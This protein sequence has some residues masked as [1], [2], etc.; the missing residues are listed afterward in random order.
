[1][2]TQLIKVTLVFAL[3]MLAACGGSTTG[4]AAAPRNVPDLGVPANPAPINAATAT[5]STGFSSA[6]GLFQGVTYDL[7]PGVLNYSTLGAASELQEVTVKF[8]PGDNSGIVTL[9]GASYQMIQISTAPLT[10]TATT[11][12]GDLLVQVF[13]VGANAFVAYVGHDEGTNVLD[14]YMSMGANTNPENL[15]TTGIAAY[16]GLTVGYSNHASGAYNALNGTVEF[17]VDFG[18]ATMTGAGTL[19][20]AAT[21]EAYLEFTVPETDVVGNAFGGDIN[22]TPAQSGTTLDAAIIQG[23]FFG[24]SGEDVAGTFAASGTDADGALTV[25]GAF[26]AD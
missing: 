4:P 15:P 2:G 8:T 6:S 1:M 18:E 3:L 22:V 11:A 20:N 10:Y 24:P 19:N 16:N 12:T 23:N 25:Q 17:I 26:Q 13:T 14:G 9:N 5:A 21:G 7:R